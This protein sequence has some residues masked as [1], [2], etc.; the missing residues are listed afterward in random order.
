[1]RKHE[2]YT[3]RER[4]ERWRMGLRANVN[5]LI[6]HNGVLKDVVCALRLG[7]A[8]AAITYARTHRQSLDC[9]LLV[10]YDLVV[11]DTELRDGDGL[12]L[13]REIRRHTDAVV[14]A[15]TR[16][17][18]E[19]ELLAAVEAGSDDYMQ[20]PVSPMAF[21]GRVRAALRRARR[22]SGDDEDAAACGGLE[23]DPA[24]YEARLNGRRLRLTPIEFQLLLH[25]TR[26]DGRVA[27]HA[28]LRSLIWGEDGDVY[29]PC[30]RKYIQ[31][32]RQKLAEVPDNAVSI[33]TVPW[34]GYK[35]VSSAGDSKE[36][37]DQDRSDEA[38]PRPRLLR[39]Q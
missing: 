19:G 38:G 11:V 24:R 31:H 36:P 3:W 25:L 35:L 16:R 29:E 30:L 9:V 2:T 5:V 20:V 33:V 37:P 17:Y 7:W 13:L 8:S 22:S 12:N 1:M 21:V 10:S 14:I 15:V 32:L 18:D 28:S 39:A 23:V 6:V 27:R 26:H 4:P 34:V